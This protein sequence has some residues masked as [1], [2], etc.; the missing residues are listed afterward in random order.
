MPRCHVVLLNRV[1]SLAVDCFYLG[2]ID[3]ELTFDPE[4]NWMNQILNA[5]RHYVIRRCRVS[6]IEKFVYFRQ[7]EWWNIPVNSG[8][9]CFWKM[10]HNQ[11]K[12]KIPSAALFRPEFQYWKFLP[13]QADASGIEKFLKK[14][15]TGIFFDSV[16]QMR[17]NELRGILGRGRR[18]R[19]MR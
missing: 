12:S 8:Q 16:I 15:L 7:A 5:T 1:S 14:D 11:I 2:A 18:R 3:P 9:F 19:R 6:G 4:L 13:Y 17:S 10:L